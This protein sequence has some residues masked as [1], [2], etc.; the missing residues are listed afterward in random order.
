ML[1]SLNK[2]FKGQVVVLLKLSH[3]VKMWFCRLLIIA[4][5]AFI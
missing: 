3:L 5:S 4:G 2:V 1:S